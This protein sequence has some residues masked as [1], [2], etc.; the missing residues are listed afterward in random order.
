[1]YVSG[2]GGARRRLSIEAHYDKNTMAQAQASLQ[3]EKD[4]PPPALNCLRVYFQVPTWRI[5]RD[6]GIEIKYVYRRH[7][8]IDIDIHIHI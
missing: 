7:I 2:E 4:L 6:G 5:K 8:D 1:M 3:D